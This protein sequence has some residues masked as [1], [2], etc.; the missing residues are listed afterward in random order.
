MECCFTS[1]DQVTVG[2]GFPEAE[3]SRVISLP[4]LTTMFPS[5]GLA[6]T[7]G[8]TKIENFFLHLTR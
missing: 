4:F 6:R 1:R 5:L 2:T 3:H 8:G 7:L